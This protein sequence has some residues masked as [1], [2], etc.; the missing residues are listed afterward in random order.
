MSWVFFTNHAAVLLYVA[1]HPD[2]TVREM[3]LALGLGRR[4]VLRI[5][6]ELERDG[7]LRKTLVGRHT[8]YAVNAQLPLR[9]PAFRH[10]SV[11][12]LL[13]LLAPPPLA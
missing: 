11:E 12:G 10:L 3:V 13:R 2:T 5:T 8:R 1:E 7:Y 9:R 4:T 6:A